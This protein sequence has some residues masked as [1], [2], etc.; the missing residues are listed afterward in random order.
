[1]TVFRFGQT[2]EKIIK[3]QRTEK[4]VRKEILSTIEMHR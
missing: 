2:F 3:H 4:I 1:M